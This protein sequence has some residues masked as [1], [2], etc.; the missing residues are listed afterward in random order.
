MSIFDI[1]KRKK[2]EEKPKIDELVSL[3]KSLEKNEILMS[4]TSGKPGA[5]DS[6]IGGEPYLPRD[7]EWPTYTSHDDGETR[8]LSFFC[9]VNLSELRV[10]DKDMVLPTQGMLYFFY[11]CETS[12][13]GFDPEDNGAARV[14]YYDCTDGFA[15][16][17]L[18]EEIAEEHRIPELAVKFSSRSSYPKYEELDL[19]CDTSCQWEDYDKALE[20]LGVDIDCDPEDHK[21]L[22]YADIIQNEMLTEC[23]RVSRG[24]YCGDPESY[25][26]TPEEME[27]IINQ[28]AKD[29]TLLMQISTIETDDF[30]WMFGDCGMLY[31]YI[32][33][34]DLAAKNFENVN[35]S[36]QCG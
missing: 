25:R 30:E 32:R 34:E 13:W 4:V 31:F 23:E 22:G 36:V 11:E 29:W 9:Q 18:P 20:K 24:L 27:Q 7:F 17:E 33:K 14:F 26:S 5:S 12:L 35:F 10:Y 1:F 19:H 21:L 28:R 2:K 6:K 15:P 3:A 16:L 8:P